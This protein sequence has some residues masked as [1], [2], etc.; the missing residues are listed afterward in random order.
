VAVIFQRRSPQV[1]TVLIA[2]TLAMSLIVAIDA[3]NGGE[4]R[5]RLA[6]LP[7]AIWRGQIWRLVTWPFIQGGPLSLIFACVTLHVFGSELVRAWGPRRF[8][9]YVAGIVLIAGIGTTLL[10]LVLPAARHL[11]QLGGLVIGDALVIAWARQFPDHSV[12]VNLVLP[13]RG[14]ELVAVIVATTVIFAV[15]SGIAWMLPELLGVAAALLYGA[16]PARR[17][18]LKLKLAWTRR[19]LR[20]VRGGRFDERD[21]A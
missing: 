10:A 5:Q 6:L 14:R 15:F 2:A 7:E 12:S 17:P 13:V 3:G 11:P 9:R 19:N 18:W 21:E 8:V 16:R 20:V 4:L 1:T